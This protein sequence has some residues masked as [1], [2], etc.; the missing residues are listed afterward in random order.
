R[1]ASPAHVKAPLGFG[2][3]YW[4]SDPRHYEGWEQIR[5][6]LKGLGRKPTRRGIAYELASHLLDDVI[7]AS[8]GIEDSIMRL[9]AHVGELEHYAKGQELKA[10]DGVPFGLAHESATSAWY[11]FTDLLTWCRTLAERMEDQRVIGSSRSRVWS[12][13]SSLSASGKSA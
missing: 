2:S 8:G 3:E 5:D 10:K 11:A 13:R 4:N 1:V 9:R 6:R 12:P 7:V